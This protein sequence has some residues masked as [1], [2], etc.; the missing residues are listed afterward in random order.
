MEPPVLT[1][2]GDWGPQQLCSPGPG[3]QR[4]HVVGVRLK[5][6]SK[7]SFWRDDTGLNGIRLKCDDGKKLKPSE[8]GP[9][10]KWMPWKNVTEGRKIT[11]VRMRSD[12]GRHLG[13]G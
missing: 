1:D 8:E 12:R 4:R 5:I 11:R 9:W 13:D 6:H 3:N 2:H 10:G 7:Q